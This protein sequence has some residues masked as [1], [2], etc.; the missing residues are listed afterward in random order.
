MKVTN[1]VSGSHGVTVGDE[2][3]ASPTSIF[4][5]R[6]VVVANFLPLHTARD[7]T[8]G[9]WCF[10]W[11]EDSLLLQMKDGFSPEIEVVYVGSLKVD[12]DAE[13]QEE[14]SQELLEEFKC[15]PTF[16]APHL[17]RSFYHGF[18]KRHLW[19]LFHYMLP[20]SAAQGEL[21]DKSLFGAYISANRIFADKAVEAM[22]SDEDYI[23]IHDYHL[24]L[25]PILLRKRLSQVK[26]GFF[27]H[28]PFPSSEIYK[29]LPVRD[30][31]LKG[32]LNA[33]VIGFQTF[34][35]ARHF[36]SC[37]SRLLGLDYKFKHGYIGIE[38]FGRIVSIKI[39]PVGVHVG[40]LEKLLKCPTT[41]A[42]VQEIKQRFKGKTL[43]L[44]IDDMDIF[45]GMSLKLLAFEFMLQR[46]QNLRGKM[47]L[48]QIANPPRTVGKNVMETRSEVISI[49]ERINSVYGSPGYEPVVFM[50]YSIPYHMKIAYY[51]MADC[52]I[53]N[54]V[55]DG[56]NLVPY[57]Y[58]VCRQGTE[59]IDRHRGINMVRCTSTLIVS[60][61]I[62][63]SPSLSGAIKVNPWSLQDVA[64]A[65]YH[66]SELSENVRQLHH[67]K[68]YRYVISHHV[69]Y[70]VQSF[71]QELER[72]CQGN[73]NQKYYCLGIGLN[74]R[75][76]S[77]SP[78]FR[79]LSVDEL[80]SS[81]KRTNRRAIF[82]DYDGTIMPAGSACKIPST[83]LISILNDLCTDPQ[84][85]VFIV[86]GRERTALGEWFCSCTNL[87]IAAEHGYF[88]RWNVDS[89]WES[90]PPFGVSFEWRNTVE[91]V[92]K[93]YTE[94]TDGSFIESKESALVWNYQDADFEF[95][96]CQAKELSSHL[97]SLL[98][99]D[100]V[101]V[102]R[103]HYIV[104]VIPQGVGKGRAVDKI[105]GQL[106]AN[107]KPPELIICV[108][109]DRSDEDMFQSINNAT[110]KESSTAA[111]EVFAC[112]V[113]Q[114][115]SSAKYYI[116]ETSDVLL[117]L[118]AL[119]Q[120]Q[121]KIVS[122]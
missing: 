55:R 7:K 58:V 74:F 41:I 73:C 18:C 81:Y 56:M 103:G 78:D 39:A 1:I 111:P 77:L 95:G 46:N 3:L 52:C 49:V 105:L 75:V 112:T 54:A 16:L 61:F 25:L 5:K 37:C 107:G 87:G 32:L 17:Q 15:I 97:E 110:K 47:V 92:M 10:E 118:K 67:E 53:V 94:A 2:D 13:E 14:V 109:N 63:C 59:E 69:A 93:S 106:V 100:P 19:P 22:N 80:V 91:R 68:H 51:V 11:D 24:M 35:Y 48:I 38:Y 90:S 9:K 104:E 31:L 57:E 108:G 21:F 6:Q 101:V 88:I 50:D 26:L 115:P 72:A 60:E 34:D 43:F 76:V 12:V 84:N 40:R 36:L 116:D 120:S 33:D 83:R 117:L 8:T 23:W 113:G 70:W 29:T 45:K 86:S 114:K 98:A 102:R 44:G 66:A 89:D 20:I 62:G 28:S 122:P 65:L 64:D 119:V 121:N 96:S 85:T 30:Q 82:L 79:K 27:L 99:N 42:K 4:L 71:L